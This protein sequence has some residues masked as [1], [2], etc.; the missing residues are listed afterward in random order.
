MIIIECDKYTIEKQP[1]KYYVGTSRAKVELAIISN[2]SEEEANSLLAKTYN[3][4]I[5]TK[6]S[7]QLQLAK[8]LKT[9]CIMNEQD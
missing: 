6:K 8:Y 4:N 5:N 9:K 1:M 3:E 7:V 2:I